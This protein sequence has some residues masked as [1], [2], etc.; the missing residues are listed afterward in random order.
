MSP[1]VKIKGGPLRSNTYIVYQGKKAFIVDAGVEP[2][3]LYKV[4]E[5]M[6]LDVEFVI[7]THGHFDHVYY[8]AQLTRNYEV[9]AYL[10]ANDVPIMKLSAKFGES[11]YGARF[12][13]PERLVPLPLEEEGRLD[14]GDT[15]V[16]LIH[17]PG[18]SPGSICV[19]FDDLILTGDTLFKGTVGRTDLPGGSAEDMIKSLKRIAS[20]PPHFK[21]LPGHGDETTIMAELSSNQF[22]KG[23]IDV[24]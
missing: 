22:L 10:H 4:L 20:L 24:E 8:V 11:F 13:Y 2:G 5:A 17:T 14:L 7:L 23:L 1:Y 9:S 16:R 15:E 6:K 19:V 12:E 18:H 21:V 3:K